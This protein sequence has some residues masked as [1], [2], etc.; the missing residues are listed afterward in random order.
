M[1]TLRKLAARDSARLF[2][3]ENDPAVWAVGDTTEPYTREQIEAFVA[4]Q[5]KASRAGLYSALCVEGQL[6]LIIE[7]DERA[8][9]AI[10]LFDYCPRCDSAFIGILIIS[11]ERRKGYAAAALAQLESFSFNELGLKSLSARVQRDN[12]ASQHLFRRAGFHVRE[13]EENILIF[14]KHA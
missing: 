5:M 1:V 2:V 13:M 3:W 8:V 14:D 6:R 9:G 12:K 4:C 7:A 11:K 10:D